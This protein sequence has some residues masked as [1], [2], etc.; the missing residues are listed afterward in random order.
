MRHTAVRQALVTYEK[1]EE[2]EIS[3]IVLFYVTDD[4]ELEDS[5]LTSFLGKFLP[6]YMLP[7]IVIRM[8]NLPNTHNGKAD[9]E[10]LHTV[11]L[12]YIQKRKDTLHIGNEVE[13]KLSGIWEKILLRQVNPHDDF[14]HSGGHSISAIRLSSAIAHEF[15]IEFGVKVVFMFRTIV[16]QAVEINKRKCLGSRPLISRIPDSFFY[17]LSPAQYSIWLDIAKNETAQS[18]NINGVYEIHGMLPGVLLQEACYQV[19]DRHEILRTVIINVEGEP[20]QKVYQTGRGLEAVSIVDISNQVNSQDRI[21]QIVSNELDHAFNL[22]KG[23]LFRICIIR[24][25]ELMHLMVMTVHHIIF[26]EWSAYVFM[27][28]FLSVCSALIDGRDTRMQPLNLQFRDFSAWQR[29]LLQS[30]YHKKTR[31]YWNNKISMGLSPTKLVGDNINGSQNTAGARIK[32]SLD[33]DATSALNGIAQHWDI[34]P[35]SLMVSVLNVFI[36]SSTKERDVIIGTPVVGRNR[37]ELEDQIGPYLST[38]II[39]NIIDENQSM[40]EFSQNVQKEI[41]ES[42]EHADVPVN[43]SISRLSNERK[44]F[45]IGFTWHDFELYQEELSANRS[46]KIAEA[47]TAFVDN[48]KVD[49]WF[50]GRKKNGTIEITIKYRKVFYNAN[51]ISKWA[52]LLIRVCDIIIKD[53][54]GTIENILFKLSDMNIKDHENQNERK[55]EINLKKFLDAKAKVPQSESRMMVKEILLKPGEAPVVF[56]PALHGFDLKRWIIDNKSFVK[57]KLNDHGAIL[58]RGFNIKD[59]DGFNDIVSAIGV[60]KVKYMDQSSPRSSIGKSLYTS[61]DH[62]AS[63]TINLHSELSYSHDWPMQILFFCLKKAVEGGQTPIADNR[64]IL[65]YLPARIRHKFLE[66]G[67]MYQRNLRKGLGLSWQEVYQTE[68]K[69]EVERYCSANGISFQW[70]DAEFLKISWKKPAIYRHP[71]T[72]QDI[73]FNHGYFFNSRHIKALIENNEAYPFDTFYGDGENIE[74]DVFESLKKAYESSRIEF[75]WEE[76]DILLLDNM[77]MAHARNPFSGERKVYVGM[78][79]PYSKVNQL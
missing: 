18:Y 47:N 27:K 78:N 20:K 75:D 31:E 70:V 13:N 5:S 58:F 16:Q 73:W 7:S 63:Q 37:L 40:R 10:R 61:T 52:E 30:E 50:H 3:H 51:T 46:V 21:E 62:P 65:Q 19:I 76:G 1:D 15:G 69:D 53:P 48:V 23:P 60:E 6:A 28:D 25:S 34:T 59:V 4:P 17:A 33:S 54:S 8:N 24:V 32:F 66:K 35:F 74:D 29:N 72:D 14:F 77:T 43:F 12:H 67:I 55:K 44:V 9:N 22:E 41:L 11:W 64:K 2:T 79:D 57:R 39:H 36:Y 38:I 45:N 71:L 56:T 26:D 68:S 42:V 49:V